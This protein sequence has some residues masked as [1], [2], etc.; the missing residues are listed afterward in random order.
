[1][2]R[3]LVL[4]L[5]AFSLHASAA[6]VERVTR[7]NLAIEGIP[8]I[9][10]G[11]HPA[12]APL[13]VLARRVLRGLDAG[14]APHRQHAVR[15]HEP[16]ARRRHADGRA[17]ADHLLRRARRAAAAG[18]R[19]VR[20]RASPT[21]A[22]R[23]ATRITSSSTSTPR[24]ADPVRL[25]DGRGRADTGVWSPDGTK[26][27]FPWTARTGVADRRL[28]RRPARPHGSPAGLRGPAVGWNA[29]DWSPDGKSLLLD[30][31]R[32][33]QRE[34]SL[35]LRPRDARE[36]GD[37]A[38]EGEGRSRRQLL[39]RRQGRVLHVRSRQRVPHPALR[40]PRERARSRRSLIT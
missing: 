6:E 10:Q 19:P 33:G 11:A 37:R 1:M 18:R 24:V 12:P 8:E 9:P 5:A 28:H 21:S 35:D 4:A 36:A 29:A 3:L 40:R 15:Q 26:Y 17:P 2:T 13:P 30:P 25:T 20:A 23:A 27:A 38:V 22:T 14:R 31:L 16:A 34:L 32:L 39:A 7:G